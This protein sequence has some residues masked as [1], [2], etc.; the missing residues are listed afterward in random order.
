MYGY[1]EMYSSRRN[2]KETAVVRWKTQIK[3]QPDPTR[4]RAKCPTYDW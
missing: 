4:R 1:F 2:A 3:R